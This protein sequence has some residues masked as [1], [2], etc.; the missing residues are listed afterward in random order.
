MEAVEILGYIGALGIGLMLGLTGSGGSLMAVPI[1]TYLFHIN[2]VTT[3]AYSLFVVG[4][5]AAVGTTRNLS[6]GIIDLKTALV[7][8]LPCLLAVYT[9]RKFLVPMLPEKVVSVGNF[10]LSKDMAIML[11]FAILVL[12]A[13][14]SMIGKKVSG[15]YHDQILS[16]KFTMLISQGIIIGVLTGIVGIGGGFLIVPVL[17]LWLGMPMK[18][19]VAT[20][21]FIISLKSMVGFLGDVGH[22]VIDWSFLLF[23][24]LISTLGILIGVQLSKHIQGEKLKEVFGWFMLI[25][26][27]G[28]LC[29]ELAWPLVTMCLQGVIL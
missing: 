15:K 23:F 7:F 20:S 12:V 5:S 18:K 25:M 21:L 17:V 2:P 10:V 14:F 22:F 6:K 26:A 24:T 19:A 13:A 4:T 28:I 27:I 16:G 11:L 29:F 8:A 1:L 9:T 3:T